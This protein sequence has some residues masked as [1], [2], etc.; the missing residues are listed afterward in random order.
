MKKTVIKRR[1]RVPASTTK[2]GR[3]PSGIERHAA[4]AEDLSGAP[5]DHAHDDS[6]IQMSDRAAA[7]TLVAVGRARRHADAE[8]D[9]PMTTHRI[10]SPNGWNDG[11]PKR[12]RQRKSIDSPVNG[13][14][15]DD[16]EINSRLSDH[17][18]TVRRN[19]AAGRGVEKT[20][21]SVQPPPPPERL[22]VTT[23]TL[24]NTA[25]GRGLS[26][27]GTPADSSTR[28]DGFSRNSRAQSIT[29]LPT[30]MVPYPH[31]LQQLH[32]A[33]IYV[34]SHQ[35]H[36]R[37]HTPVKETSPPSASDSR[38]SESSMP[39]D[40][41]NNRHSAQNGIPHLTE[42]D[43]KAEGWQRPRSAAHNVDLPPLSTL[44]DEIG[45]D[46]ESR[47]AA[48]PP[49]WT[50]HATPEDLTYL[51]RNGTSSGAGLNGRIRDHARVNLNYR[52]DRIDQVNGQS[53]HHQE[54][55][56]SLSVALNH[57]YESHPRVSSNPS[58]QDSKSTSPEFSHT[59]HHRTQTHSPRNPPMQAP[60]SRPL[61]RSSHVP[62]SSE[63]E[64]HYREL[65]VQKSVWEEMMDKTRRYM[66]DVKRAIEETRERE[67]DIPNNGHIASVPLPGRLP[68]AQKGVGRDR[69]W[70]WTTNST[71][72]E[73]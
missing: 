20:Q 9:Y 49:S 68:S 11:E 27:S 32:S 41:T 65:Q 55:K 63:L 3:H 21:I 10:P 51:A 4:S 58:T 73:H 28:D 42:P 25:V 57:S 8:R 67:K 24:S 40:P 61:S 23:L 47:R 6:S 69:I 1:K 2:L 22:E 70:S 29:Q 50:P 7:E 71:E 45:R 46:E 19:G 52:E 64:A 38:S 15:S 59:H 48:Q 54:S 17:G 66:E 37:P 36:S 18:T 13:E 56:L 43:V 60:P 33:P 16:F 12:K 34:N 44:H 31:T 5:Y 72:K 35:S 26:R 62:S 30:T 39:L 14:R 53:A